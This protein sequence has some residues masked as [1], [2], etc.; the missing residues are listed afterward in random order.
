[1]LPGSENTAVPQVG[2]KLREAELPLFVC[3]E[4]LLV[5]PSIVIALAG[6]ITNVA[7]PPPDACRHCLQKHW[8][9]PLIGPVIV[10]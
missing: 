8:Y 3:S 6:A 10:T 5:G 2:Q 1:M 7:G 4:N 9:G